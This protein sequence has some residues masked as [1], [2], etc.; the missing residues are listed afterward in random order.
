MSILT[1]EHLAQLQ[2]EHRLTRRILLARQVE[3]F[4]RLLL[5]VLERTLDQRLLGVHRQQR[6]PAR[7]GRRA[8]LQGAFQVI[9]QVV[10][11]AGLAGQ[12]QEDPEELELRP[13]VQLAVPAGEFLGEGFEECRAFGTGRA[14]CGQ[15]FQQS[16]R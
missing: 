1:L 12:R 11:P 13:P 4:D 16:L 7:I 5:G 9:E 6:H 8:E 2:E 14:R 15:G 3:T 10:G